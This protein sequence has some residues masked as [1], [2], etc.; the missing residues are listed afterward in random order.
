MEPKDR[1]AQ[2]RIDAGM[3][4]KELAEKLGVDKATMSNWE[5]GRRP[6]TLERLLQVAQVLGVGITYLLGLDGPIP[7]A[8]VTKDMLPALHRAPV[9]TK[10][11]GWALVNS[12]KQQLVFADGGTMPFD[13]ILE[14][15]FTI[16]PAFSVSLREAGEPLGIECFT[17][18]K[19]G[20]IQ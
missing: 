20:M 10:S 19:H 5:S 8:P 9:W 3:T 11:Y 12:Q 15:I 2:A 6:L 18:L 17:T 14:P 1:V 4:S 7:G 13:A 16:P